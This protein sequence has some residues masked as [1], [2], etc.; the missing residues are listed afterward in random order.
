MSSFIGLD[1]V[2]P[3]KDIWFG[4][5]NGKLD[6]SRVYVGVADEEKFS[7]LGIRVVEA[8]L[9]AVCDGGAVF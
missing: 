1:P 8:I 6:L 7:H 3:A 5:I 4:K 9:W 2:R